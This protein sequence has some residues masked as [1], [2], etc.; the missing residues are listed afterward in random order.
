MIRIVNIG[1]REIVVGGIG[2]MLYQE[3]FPLSVAIKYW[4]DRCVEVSLLHVADELLK[5]GDFSEE[6]VVI[7]IQAALSER[8]EGDKPVSLAPIKDF[9][10]A[11]Y[12]EQ[13]LMIHNYL[14]G[15]TIQELR[16]STVHGF[17]MVNHIAGMINA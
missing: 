16:E 11:D 15:S 8:I 6:Q 5:S 7:K 17:G 14:F 12:D 13:R 1:G 9:C 2:K 10:Y 3:G 4:N